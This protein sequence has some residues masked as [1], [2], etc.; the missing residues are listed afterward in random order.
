[1]ASAMKLSISDSLFKCFLPLSKHCW[2][3]AVAVLHLETRVSPFDDSMIL[4]C[5]D[6]SGSVHL[7]RVSTTKSH[8]FTVSTSVGPSVV[9]VVSK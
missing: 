1:M 2:I 8:H 6:R 7:Y 3:T 5:G 4:M 9:Q